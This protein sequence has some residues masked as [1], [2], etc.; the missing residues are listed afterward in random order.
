MAKK[1]VRKKTVRVKGHSRKVCASYTGKKR[2]KRPANKGK[3]CTRW[4]KSH[5]RKVC[6]KF[7]KR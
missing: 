1:C 6:R 4:G 7:G 2:G 5:G 3:K